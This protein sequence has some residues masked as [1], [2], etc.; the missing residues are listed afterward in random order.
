MPEGHGGHGTRRPAP[1]RRALLTVVSV[2]V[3]LIAAI[4][5]ASRGGH[6]DDSSS[7]PASSSGASGSSG[8]NADSGQG[9]GSRGAKGSAPTAPSGVAPVTGKT[10]GIPS[11]F[12][13]TGQGAQSA[14]ANYSVALGG[15]GMF[16]ATTRH[17]IVS[18]VY[19]PQAA[20]ASRSAL[21]KA[22]TDPAFLQRV[23]LRSDGTVPK[24]LT[25][26]SRVNPVGAR[27]I[28]STGDTATVSVWYSSL[29]GLAGDG[30]TSPVTESWYTNTF[31]MTWAAGDWKIT[32][33]QQK[34]GP[35]PVGRDQAASSAKD[36]TDAVNGF[37]GFTYAR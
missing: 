27:L 20:A 24:G 10:A 11:G 33:Y 37:G 13:H 26:I 4:A 3:L 9:S 28:G 16:D 29:F 18:T 34:D 6:K 25:F 32:D 23:G 14:A 22:Y 31:E 15:T 30:S 19:A 21:D 1:P 17:T 12:P 5:F 36:M 35:A 2:F 7:S 8:S